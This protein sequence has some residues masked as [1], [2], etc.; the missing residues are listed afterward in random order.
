MPRQI[1]MFGKITNEGF[2][3][4]AAP[5]KE[6][7]PAEKPAFDP[8]ATQK[9]KFNPQDYVTKEVPAFKASGPKL[10]MKDLT[11]PKESNAKLLMKKGPEAVMKANKLPQPKTIAPKAK[12][13]PPQPELPEPKS[14]LGDLP[15]ETL[16]GS[17]DFGGHKGFRSAFTSRTPE[18]EPMHKQAP[19]SLANQNVRPRERKK[20][21]EGFFSKKTSPI[22]RTSPSPV[23]TGNMDTPALWR[24][25][26]APKPAEPAKTAEP[27]PGPSTP[28]APVQ[29]PAPSA[30]PPT[31]P[32]PE[33][34]KPA[35]QAAPGPGS[36]PMAA[37]PVTTTPKVV[38]P[39]AKLSG[40][41]KLNKS[42]K[43]AAE[44]TEPA[45]E[46]EPAKTEPTDVDKAAAAA[47]EKERA[48]QN[49]T[50]PQ[51]IKVPKEAKQ[52]HKNSRKGALA[53]A[54]HAAF[55]PGLPDKMAHIGKQFYGK[56]RGLVNYATHIKKV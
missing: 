46:P 16:G 22:Q 40:G 2:F 54:A 36:E 43:P 7:K 27:A 15:K 24:K 21:G 20:L 53:T 30:A 31:P 44:P 50:K 35:A 32:T 39:S 18:A 6:F 28:P 37:K 47:V 19:P 17:H 11:P 26:A 1:S 33:T 5:G 38:E 25:N 12:I 9:V 8:E 3:S 4:G 48:K 10:S 52:S 42:K 55:T 13:E 23:D 51:E 45:A 49:K 34:P 41:A 14:P 56:A 29:A